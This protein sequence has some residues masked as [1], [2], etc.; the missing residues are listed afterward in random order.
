MNNME[1]MLTTAQVA[2]ILGKNVITLRRWVREKGGPPCHKIG[3]SGRY[4]EHELM[5]WIK[6]QSCEKT[7]DKTA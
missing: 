6:E 2:E 7:D 3:G 5:E 1:K 4:F